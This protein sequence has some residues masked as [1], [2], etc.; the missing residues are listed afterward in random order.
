MVGD[1]YGD[2]F[3]NSDSVIF[4]TDK[5]TLSHYSTRITDKA[6]SGIYPQDNSSFFGN[7]WEGKVIQEKTK[8]KGKHTESRFYI[9]SDFFE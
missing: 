5:S 6:L 4:K 8:K 9:K 3:L 2:D 1:I 7:G